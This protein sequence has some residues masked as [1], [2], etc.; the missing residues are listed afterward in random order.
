MIYFFTSFKEYINIGLFR[1]TFFRVFAFVEIVFLQ[2]RTLGC[3]LEIPVD[4][5]DTVDTHVDILA[6][7]SH[8]YVV[9]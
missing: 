2:T 6:H 8:F 7:K 5:L 9:S 3:G 4:T 1:L